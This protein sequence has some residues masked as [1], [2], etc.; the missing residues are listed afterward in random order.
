MI[1]N[2]SNPSALP[3]HLMLD[4]APMDAIHSEFLQL[5]TA[6]EQSGE[7]TYLEHLDAL[8]AHTVLHFEQENQWMEAHDFP[9]ASCHVRE[10]DTVLDVIRDV[11][12]CTVEGDFEVVVRLAQELPNWF[13]HH[14]DTMDAALA[15][16]LLKAD[17]IAV[18]AMATTAC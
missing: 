14:I 9:S 3:E 15:K 2:L 18:T 1:D 13:S 4:Y 11:R 8:I 6:L 17:A 5:C 12:K 7:G 16:F 10:H